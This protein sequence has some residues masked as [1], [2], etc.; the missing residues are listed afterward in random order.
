MMA[1]HVTQPLLGLVDATVIGRLGEVHLLGAVAIGAI[2]FDLVFWGLGSLR[3]S[4]AALTA[5]AHGA[6]LDDEVSIALAR[7]LALAV[8]MGLLLIALQGPIITAS[9]AIMDASPAVGEAARTYIAIRIWSAPFALANYAI[10]GSLI[11]RARTDLGLLLQVLIN[12]A[13]IAFTLALVEGLGLGIAGA[14][15]GTLAA[16]IGGTLAGLVVL[17]RLR[18]L[19]GGWAW[20][21][22]GEAGALRRLLAVNRD[23]AIRS[24][25]LVAAFAFFTA[26]GSRAG[27][28]TL[29]ANAVLYNLF[30]FGGYL[31]DGFATAAEQLC[32]QAT[33]ARD[34]T[35]FR[36][37]ARNALWLSVGT[38]V[39]VT[40]AMLAGGHAFIAFVSTNA[41][42]REAAGAVLPFAALTPVIGATAFAFDGIFVGATWTRAMRDLML[43]SLALYLGTWWLTA[44]WSNAGLWTAFVVFLGSRGLGQALAYPHLARRTFRAQVPG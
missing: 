39:A 11:G 26:Q 33:G 22:V 16:E 20:R 9:L 4:T 43:A 38:G 12:L 8:A 40:L 44:G 34:E 23:V 5:Q 35:G 15:A 42:V 27:D 7:A 30:L 21:D 28:V 19:D 18:A 32:G 14:A 31:L 17:R 2:V 37:T 36:R 29:A 13:N 24:F 25:A 10:L 41:Q 6:G 3:L 1:A